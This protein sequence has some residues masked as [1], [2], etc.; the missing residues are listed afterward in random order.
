MKPSPV[1]YLIAGSNGAGKTTFA[2]EHFPNFVGPVDFLN[3]DLIARGLSPFDPDKAAASAGRLVLKRIK[4]LS[5]ER[6]TFAIETTLAGRSYAR[7]IRRMR[8]AGYQIHLYFLWIPGPGLALRRIQSR[9]KKGGHNI[10][11]AV[12][13]RRYGRT[14][15]NLF[16][17]YLAL[18]DHALILDNSGVVPRPVAAKREGSLVASDVRLMEKIRKQAMRHGQS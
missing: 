10:P 7:I 2:T 3:A 18:A 8:E 5:H 15:Q 1:L 17:I 12:V 13:R 16:Q 9:V 6:A 11:A 4:E 14:L